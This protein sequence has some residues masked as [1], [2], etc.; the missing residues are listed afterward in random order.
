MNPTRPGPKG[1]ETTTLPCK[2]I[3]V[4]RRPDDKA[5]VYFPDALSFIRMT[6]GCDETEDDRFE[7]KPGSD[8]WEFLLGK[9]AD[10]ACPEYEDW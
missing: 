2:Q 1:S 5:L 6:E 4:M 9:S 7:L 10:A 8:D 3:L